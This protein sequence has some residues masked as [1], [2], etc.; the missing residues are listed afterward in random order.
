MRGGEKDC[1]RDAPDS[2]GAAASGDGAGGGTG[3]EGG[4]VPPPP[5]SPRPHPPPP[6]PGAGRRRARP[7]PQ[8]LPAGP[9]RSGP[10]PRTPPLPPAPSPP[11]PPPPRPGKK[12]RAQ[13]LPVPQTSCKFTP[14]PPAPAGSPVP[15]CEG[16]RPP[17]PLPPGYI[18]SRRSRPRPGPEGRGRAGSR[19]PRQRRSGH[20]PGVRGWTGSGAGGGA[21]HPVSLPAPARTPTHPPVPDP[22]MGV[23]VPGR[24]SRTLR[25]P[26]APGP[27]HLALKVNPSAA[28]FPGSGNL[29]QVQVSGPQAAPA[30]PSRVPPA[31][32]L[33]GSPPRPPFPLPSAPPPLPT[34]SPRPPPPL[35][36]SPA[37]GAPAP[38]VTPHP[39][40]S[41]PGRGQ[42][43]PRGPAPP[44]PPHRR[45]AA[46]PAG[47]RSL[48]CGSTRHAGVCS[49]LPGPK[50]VDRDL[51]FN[52]EPVIY[53][54]RFCPFC[55]FSFSSQSVMS[56]TGAH[57]YAPCGLSD[58]KERHRAGCL[59]Q[60]S[61]EDVGSQGVCCC[62]RTS[63]AAT[64]VC[65]LICAFTPASGHKGQG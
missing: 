4:M 29:S 6:G 53:P 49:P 37:P 10:G 14:T 30:A 44:R 9:G 26:R 57:Y 35:S 50:A 1:A 27:A 24:G 18:R 63:P 5:P 21:A 31:R 55:K 60:E 65:H 11:R 12:E 23:G 43:R 2:S 8:T 28:R 59:S 34:S 51:A 36:P 32:G 41:A 46:A 15:G 3:R 7:L 19:D 33:Q 48:R 20:V 54:L 42:H 62:H 25:A 13:G 16:P 47:K 61:R 40:P 38:A 17:R 22:P 39:L 45:P 58:P 56:R 64:G 52:L